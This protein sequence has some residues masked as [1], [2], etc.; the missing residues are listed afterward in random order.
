[1]HIVIFAINICALISTLH[2]KF[3]TMENPTGH[4]LLLHREIPYRLGYFFSIPEECEIPYAALRKPQVGQ[5][6]PTPFST[7]GKIP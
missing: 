1:M 4:L 7:L 2:A 6:H 5:F 3:D